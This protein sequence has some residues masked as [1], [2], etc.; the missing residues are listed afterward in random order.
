MSQDNEE[1]STVSYVMGSL[2]SVPIEHLNLSIRPRN[3][4]LRAGLKTALDIQRLIEKNTLSSIYNIGSLAVQEIEECL[5]SMLENQGIELSVSEIAL[6]DNEERKSTVI[7]TV[8]FFDDLPVDI[9]VQEL[10][11]DMIHRLKSAGFESIGELLNLSRAV[12]SFI[13]NTSTTL[14]R[15]INHQKDILRALI[16]REKLHPQAQYRNMSIKS[17]LNLAPE[18]TNEQGEFLKLLLQINESHSLS[19]ELSILFAKVAERD[20]DIYIK[21]FNDNLTLAQVGRQQGVTRERVR[22]ITSKTATR[23]WARINQNPGLYL[24][25]ALLVAKDMGDNL[26]LKSWR[27]ALQNR[28]IID[29]SRPARENLDSFDALCALLRSADKAKYPPTIKIDESV[30]FILE[31]PSDLSLGLIKAIEEMSSKAKRKMHQKISYM[32]GIHLSEASETLDVSPQQAAYILKHLGYKEVD[33]DWYTI[34]TAENTTRW[35]ILKAGL[36]MME[37]CGPLEFSVFCDGTRRY[38]SRFYDILAPPRVMKAHIEALGFEVEDDYVSWNETP[39]GYLA[40]SDKC[41][42]QVVEKHGT[43]VTF[44]EVVEFFQEKGF[45]IATATARVLPQ[46]PI[47]EKVETGLYKIRGRNHTWED[48]ENARSRQDPI[49]YDPEVVYGIDGLIRYKITIGSWAL[50]GVLSI[51]SNQP[52]LPDLGDGWEIFVENKSRGIAKR[53]EHLIWGLGSAF[54]AL[55]VQIG[56]RVELAFDAW[57]KPLIRISKT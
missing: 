1:H 49:D 2:S 48:I 38:I 27:L 14:D 24:Q 43:V 41:F 4:L 32:G 28:N 33:H 35:P 34:A 6:P 25:S 7:P 56:D 55:G 22:Q 50:N 45:S 36:A 17:W 37:V 10:S 5:S 54:N 47:V 57:E 16:A 3:A 11:N 23:L 39:T 13:E 26:S 12:E 18:N 19:E 52:Q 53:D 40:E 21:Y 42:V 29:S 15:L 20:L 44:Q 30:T 31:S 46:S 9:L 8:S 51:S